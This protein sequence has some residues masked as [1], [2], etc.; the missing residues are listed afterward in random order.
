MSKEKEDLS[1]KIGG[2]K[3]LD[4]LLETDMQDQ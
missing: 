3:P 2:L 1:K 4:R